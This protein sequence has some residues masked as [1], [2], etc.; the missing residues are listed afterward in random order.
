[1]LCQQKNFSM[2]EMDGIDT[3]KKLFQT[4]SMGNDLIQVVKSNVGQYVYEVMF[5]LYDTFAML[6]HVS[7]NT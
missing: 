7:S 3:F 4:Y 5:A 6:Q 1:M 2:L